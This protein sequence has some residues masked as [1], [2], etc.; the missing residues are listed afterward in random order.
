MTPSTRWLDLGCGHQLLPTWMDDG[1]RDAA[2]LVACPARRRARW[3]ASLD[4]YRRSSRVSPPTSRGCR[5]APVRSIS[6]RRTWCSSTSPTCPAAL[7]SGPRDRAGRT[8]IFHTPNRRFY[9]IALSMWVPQGRRRRAASLIEA[10]RR[11]RVSD[12][13]PDEHPAGDRRR[14]RRRGLDRRRD[15]V[16]EPPADQTPVPPLALLEIGVTRLLESPAMAGGRSNIVVVRLRKAGGRPSPADARPGHRRRQPRG[17]GRDPGAGPPR[18]PRRW[19]ADWRCRRWPRCR[20]TAPPAPPIPIRPSTPTASSR[21]CST[22]ATG[23]RSTCCSPWPTSRRSRHGE[24]RPLRGLC[25]L[26][27]ASADAVARAADKVEIMRTATRL[28]V[29][30]PGTTSISRRARPRRPRARRLSWPIVIKPRRS[31]LRTPAGWVSCSVGYAA[32]P[33]ELAP[34]ASP[35]RPRLP[36]DPAGTH[37]GPWRRRVRLLQ[38]RRAG[39]ALQPSTAARASAVGRRQRPLGERRRFRQAPAHRAAP[40]RRDRWHGVAMVEFKRD[41]R[42]DTPRLMEINGRFWGSLQLAIDAGVDFPCDPAR[43]LADAPPAPVHRIAR[44]SQPLVV[45]RRRLAAAPALLGA[46]MPARRRAKAAAVGRFLRLWQRDLHYE[47]PKLIGP[48]PVAGSRPAVAAPVQPACARRRRADARP[49]SSGSRRRWCL[50]LRRLPAPA[51]RRSRRSDGGPT[52]SASDADAA[53]GDDDRA[54]AQRAR[55]H[56]DEAGQHRGPRLSRGSPRGAVRLGRI[57][58]RHGRDDSRARSTDAST[59]ARDHHPRRQGGRA[60]R[61]PRRSPARDHR[62]HRRLD[63]ARAGRCARSSGRSRIPRSAASRARIASRDRAARRCTDATSSSSGGRRRACTRSS[64]RAAPSTRSAA[65]ICEPFI[66]NVAP[67]FWSVL[68]T[69]ERGYRALAEPEASGQHGGGR[70]HRRGVRA[71]GADAAARHDDARPRRAS[72]QPVPLRRL[73]VV[74]LLAQDRCAGWCRS[75]CSSAS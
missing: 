42:D 28:G 60:Q 26:P 9:Q 34:G 16:R 22:R 74:P 53:D 30:I 33:D 5:C 44:R 73:R 32:T 15:A 75:S 4:R 56:R 20:A 41:E 19:L 37:R 45:G 64:A 38:S 40:A 61:R 39:R 57:D 67:D 51:L 63:H 47:N 55:R 71:Q 1:E 58:R 21:R 35:C 3:S 25:R 17:A 7:R 6:S 27:V 68:K 49:G 52:P 62:V 54:G 50:R 2:T 46:R 11:R 43:T 70:A 12:R 24:P 14:W 72:A 18:P 10:A 69:V 48:A 8:F 66:P 36:A 13:L 65:S 29:P 59:P 23:P 31:R